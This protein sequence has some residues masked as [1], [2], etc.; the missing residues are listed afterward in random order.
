MT[1]YTLPVSMLVNVNVA[2]QPPLL[3]PDAFGRG[4]IIG[5]SSNGRVEGPNQL[6][7][8]Y[9]SIDAVK[10]DYGVEAPEYLIAKRYFEQVPR[11]KDVMIATVGATN[12]PPTTGGGTTNPPPTGGGGT[13]GGGGDDGGDYTPDPGGSGGDWE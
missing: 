8:I 2:Y 7:G 13:G 5:S 9:S 12:S 11:P 1:A 6:Y 4:L 3:Q 10:A